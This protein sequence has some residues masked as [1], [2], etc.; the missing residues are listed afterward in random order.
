M[1]ILFSILTCK[2]I[3]SRI[4]TQ[5]KKTKFEKCLLQLSI[6]DDFDIVSWYSVQYNYALRIIMQ[7]IDPI[8]VWYFIVTCLFFFY[9]YG[10]YLYL[11]ST[12]VE[13]EVNESYWIFNHLKFIDC[14]SY[15]IV[16]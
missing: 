5:E 11:V 7:I 12:W 16:L 4:L 1:E 6:F 3:I 15:I 13:S 10:I 2:W 8:L 9:I 14:K